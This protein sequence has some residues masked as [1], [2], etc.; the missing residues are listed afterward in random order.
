[1]VSETLKNLGLPTFIK[2]FTYIL[3]SLT[4]AHNSIRVSAIGIL[5]LRNI[6]TGISS[7]YCG[8]QLLHH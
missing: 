4:I 7:A 3:I 1:M 8:T 5:L 6:L 2:A